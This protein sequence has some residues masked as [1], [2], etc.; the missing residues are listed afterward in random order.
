MFSKSDMQHLDK[1]YEELA[2]KLDQLHEFISA[3]LNTERKNR[4]DDQQELY[5]YLKKYSYYI[6]HDKSYN[7]ALGFIEDEVATTVSKDAKSIFKNLGKVYSLIFKRSDAECNLTGKFNRDDYYRVDVSIV[8]MTDAEI[9][10]ILLRHILNYGSNPQITVNKIQTV[11]NTYTR[12]WDE[13]T[14][15]KVKQRKK[16]NGF[17][18][19]KNVVGYATLSFANNDRLILF[20]KIDNLENK[21]KT[22]MKNLTQFEV[23]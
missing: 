2:H 18:Y 12:T 22:A 15:V 3:I 21:S 20:I 4:V 5:K 13:K 14:I 11:F 23:E 17:F 6:A 19:D 9:N 1:Q 7:D 16:I 10:A 8:D